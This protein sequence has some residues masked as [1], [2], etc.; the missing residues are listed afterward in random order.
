[1]PSALK[2]ERQPHVSTPDSLFLDLGF[3]AEEARLLTIKSDL[4]NQI[5]KIVRECGY[6]QKDLAKIWSKPQPRVSE[7]LNCKLSLFSIDMLV[8]YL[9]QLG[10][11]VTFAVA[12]ERKAAS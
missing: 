10:V 9:G 11:H 12:R 2:A 7:I 5:L 6:S 3:S 8:T 4:C 1:M